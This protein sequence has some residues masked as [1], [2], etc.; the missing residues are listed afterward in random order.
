MKNKLRA[1]IVSVAT[2][3]FVLSSCGGN[4]ETT[5]ADNTAED[6]TDATETQETQ[7]I[8]FWHYLETEQ[9]E[10]LTKAVD[11]YNSSQDKVHVTM[12]YIPRDELMKQYTMGVVS[13]ELPDCGLTDST[14]LTS[15]ASMGAFEDI[16][17]LYNEW[18]NTEFLQ[19]PLDSC[20]YDD[21]LYGLP[22]D[23]NCLALYYN[24]DLLNE[25]G[26]EVPTTWTELEEACE[27][28]TNDTTKGIAI[29][30]ISNEEGTF[31]YLSWLQS[32]GG[33]VNNFN[34]NEAKESMEY[35]KGLIDNGYM[36]K[37]CVTWT[38]ADIEKQFASGQAAM[39][40]N[41]PWQVEPLAADAPDLNYS[42]AKIPKADNGEYTSVLGGEDIAI[43]KG[44]NL[45]ATWDFVSWLCSPEVSSEMCKEMGYFSPRADVDNVELYADDPVQS[46]FAE[47]LPT[48][49]SRGPSEYWPEISEAVYTAEQEI[50]TGQKDIDTALDDAQAKIDEINA[51]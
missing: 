14:N 49:E 2:L 1:V 26:V 6:T 42:V 50:L 10:V 21:K 33:D 15:Y 4:T 11:T 29:S 13:G 30:A 39:M 22:F 41:G 5:T 40:I 32:A 28:L 35:L 27:V 34:S 9:T 51:R 43:C 24:E 36:S 23:S 12:Q 3:S 25:A 48:A 19:G 44:A 8:E 7:E 18:D 38:Q 46:V 17:D 31:Q 37:E 47:I 16:T 20:Y 45:D